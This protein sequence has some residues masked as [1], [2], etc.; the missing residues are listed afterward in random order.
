MSF[1]KFL[2]LVGVAFLV[3]LGI[4]GLAIAGAIV[5]GAWRLVL[6]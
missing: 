6:Q 2:D 3:S 1:Q 5:V 4:F